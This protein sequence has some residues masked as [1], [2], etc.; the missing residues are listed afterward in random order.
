MGR[1]DDTEAVMRMLV[2]GEKRRKVVAI[3]G[4]GGLGKTAISEKVFSSS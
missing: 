1:K 3:V 4:M 2:V